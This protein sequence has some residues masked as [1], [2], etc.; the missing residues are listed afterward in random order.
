MN[1][2]AQPLIRLLAR[3]IV[4]DH[5]TGRLPVAIPSVSSHHEAPAQQRRRRQIP[6]R[7]V[8]RGFES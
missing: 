8:T 4:E 7:T 1:P 2:R 5:Q 3:W 6:S